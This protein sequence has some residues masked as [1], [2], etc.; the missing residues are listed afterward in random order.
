MKGQSGL[1]AKFEST[2]NSAETR[3]IPVVVT[4]AELLEAGFD[5]RDVSLETGTIDAAKV[6]VAPMDY[7]AV[8][9]RADDSLALPNL[10][11]DER[12]V[13]FN[14]LI[15]AQIRTIFVVRAT[16]INAF[17]NWASENLIN[18]A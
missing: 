6:T 13:G 15:N 1:M 14:D 16:A 12:S 8:N 3:S 17:L 9:Y 10:T 5:P 11:P 7:C 4:T 2:G 18:T